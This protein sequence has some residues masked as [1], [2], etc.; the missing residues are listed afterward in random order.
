MIKPLFLA[1]GP[2]GEVIVHDNRQHRLVVFSSDGD[3]LEYSRHMCG[4][5]N[6]YGKFKYITGIAA[7][8]DYLY[9]ADGQLDSIQKLRLDNGMWVKTINK[10]DSEDGKFNPYGLALDEAKSRLYICDC[11][12]HRIQV[13]NCEDNCDKLFVYLFGGGDNLNHPKDIALVPASVLLYSVAS[14]S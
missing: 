1:K 12:N 3:R 14:G 11:D 9:V 7:S 4:E 8:K 5:G 13:I 10:S 6:G 2:G